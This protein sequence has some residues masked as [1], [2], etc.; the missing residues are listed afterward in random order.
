MITCRDLLSLDSFRRITLAAGASGLDRTISWPYS[1]HT[2]TITPWVQGGEFILVSGYELGV[3]QTELLSLLEE[4]NASGLSG[5]L[6]EGGMNF[7][8][9]SS[10]VIQ[11]AEEYQI[12]LFF[13]PSVVS[14]LDLSREI[15]TLILEDQH[16]ENNRTEC[17]KHLLFSETE[18]SKELDLLLDT[19]H[20][21]GDGRYQLLIA[22]SDTPRSRRQL[23]T[24][25]SPIF[26]EI[27]LP[28]LA[29]FFED[30]AIC[31]LCGAEEAELS[32]CITSLQQSLTAGSS[33]PMAVSS[34]HS[35]R[36]AV[37]EAF[38]EARFA[39]SLLEK[40]IFSDFPL[41]FDETGSHQFLFYIEKKEW[42]LEFR[43]RY[44]K[45]LAEADQERSSH[46]F[47][48]LKA[49]LQ[50]QGNMLKTAESLFIHRNTLQYRLERISLITGRSLNDAKNRQDFQNALMI[51]EYYPFSGTESR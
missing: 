44:L 45:K 10:L 19:C 13:T 48:T 20:I 32:A 33:L 38:R 41:F 17:L 6:I 4:A 51:L 39:A 28:H 14:F 3:D 46:L 18:S 35:D 12:P 31:Y 49:Y 50:C 2:K 47:D 27:S 30:Y 42:L 21:P 7:K 9:L 22:S 37:K 26:S 40:G 15:S 11:K 8:S 24:Q 23:Q 16:S 5:I 34:V 29:A 43:D 36:T 25:L 1:K